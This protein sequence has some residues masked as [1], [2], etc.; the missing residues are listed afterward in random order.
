[1]PESCS[2]T[3]KSEKE[4]LWKKVN[5]EMQQISNLR[6]ANDMFQSL[7]NF[8]TSDSSMPPN[9]A[10]ALSSSSNCGNKQHINQHQRH[11]LFAYCPPE[12]FFFFDVCD[13]H[14]VKTL[15]QLPDLSRAH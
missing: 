8:L 15:P 7:I 6:H 5:D 4:G 2:K 1:M 3:T 11:K 10:E 13:A 14:T 12:S 9:Q